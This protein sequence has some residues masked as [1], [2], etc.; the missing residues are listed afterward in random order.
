LSVHSDGSGAAGPELVALAQLSAGGAWAPSPTAR[1]APARSIGYTVKFGFMD[2]WLLPWTRTARCS[3]FRS[4]ACVTFVTS[5]YQTN[6]GYS[7]MPPSTN[8]VVPVT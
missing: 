5:W 7:V 6:F 8:N 4:D 2:I 3:S 1:V